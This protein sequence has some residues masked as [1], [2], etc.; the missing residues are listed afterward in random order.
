VLALA[1]ALVDWWAVA[2]DRRRVEYAAK[3]TVLILLIVAALALDPV[4]DTVRAWFVLGLAAS[5]VGDVVLMLP[6]LPFAGGLGAFLLAHLAYMAGFLVNGL[7]GGPLLVGLAVAAV[8]SAV[9]GPGLVAGVRRRD[10]RL[11]GP[12]RAYMV[13]IAAMVALAVGTGDLLAA[14]GALAFFVSDALLGWGR[15]V[16]PVAGGRVV[17]HVTYHGA[18][19]ML[20]AWLAT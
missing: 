1:A 14:A 4:D 6:R 8:G 19:A 2:G 7:S 12:V 9:V 16:R 18:Q 3:P 13:V 5:L 17:V 15:F 10:R 11:V 20:V